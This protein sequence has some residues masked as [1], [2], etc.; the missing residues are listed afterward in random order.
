MKLSKNA[1]QHAGDEA[2][3]TITTR[4]TGAEVLIEVADTG[5]GIPA[6]Q[7]P[8]LFDRFYRGTG[9]GSGAGL[10]LAIADSLTRAMSGRFAVRSTVG[11]GTAFVVQ[12]PVA[13]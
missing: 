6:D 3:L 9:R 10:G 8:H 1:V 5:P 4:R 2:R 11:E 13:D 7:L 12:L